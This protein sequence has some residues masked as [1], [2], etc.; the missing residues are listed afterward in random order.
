MGRRPNRRRSGSTSHRQEHAHFYA[1]NSPC[2]A[3]AWHGRGQVR[4]KHI[5]RPIFLTLSRDRN[6][7]DRLPSRD[8]EPTCRSREPAPRKRARPGRDRGASA[9]ASNPA[10]ERVDRT[11]AAV[12]R[13]SGG[14]GEDVVG[15]AGRRHPALEGILQD[16][17]RPVHGTAACWSATLREG[18]K[19]ASSW[20]NAAYRSYGLGSADGWTTVWALTTE[21]FE[22][23]SQRLGLKLERVPKHDVG[24]AFLK[25]EVLANESLPRPVGAIGRTNGG[26]GSDSDSSVTS[27]EALLL[28]WPADQAGNED[29]DGSPPRRR[30]VLIWNGP[31][32]RRPSGQVWHHEAREIPEVSA[33]DAGTSTSTC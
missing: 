25:H 20:Q 6:L 24:Q 16:P 21:G 19:E 14:E 23:G 18:R 12:A 1:L 28:A 15:E 3:G 31:S 4:A 17:A 13:T 32:S 29:D 22:I 5:P 33:T 10:Q 7:H 27:A 30:T 26:F 11:G 8:D 2:A 9:S